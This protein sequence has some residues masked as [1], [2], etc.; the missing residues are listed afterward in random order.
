MEFFLLGI[1]HHICPIE[2]RDQV[3]FSDSDVIAASNDLIS[4]S[5]IEVLV[6]STCNRS[7]V[8]GVSLDVDKDIELVKNFYENYFQVPGLEDYFLAK[9]G[10]EALDHLF[11]L[12]MGLDSLLVGEDQILGQVSDAHLTAME[13]GSS[14]KILNKIFREAITLAKRVKTESGASDTPSSLAYLGI[15]KVQ[16]DLDLEGARAAVVG[17]GDMGQLALTY[18][19]EAGA[20]VTLC[21]RTYENSLRVAQDFEGV[22]LAPY[23][24]LPELIGKSQVLVSATASPHSI[25]RP[26]HIKK[27]EEDLFIMDLSLPRDVDPAV[28]ELEG[29][30]LYNIDQLQAISQENLAH[31]REALEAYEPEIKDLIQEVQAWVSAS[32]LDPI[33]ASMNKRCD[34]VAQETLDYIFRKTDMTHSQR[35][36]VD[37]I[38]HSALKKIAREPLLRLKDMPDNQPGK[39]LAIEVLEEVYD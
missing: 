29:V 13:I 20:R 22:D 12:T 30:S 35:I 25:I 23:Q 17:V 37:S 6:L 1:N 3:H 26:D 14:K 21:N 11:R 34:E 18:L 4:E 15:K 9:K 39:D 32:K 16:E 28:G 5:L 19:L 33:M 31:K 24:D 10:D 27:R 38:V 7:E 2:V 8:Y 36:K